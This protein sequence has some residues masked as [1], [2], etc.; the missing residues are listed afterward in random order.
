MVVL[1]SIVYNLTDLQARISL[2]AALRCLTKRH[3]LAGAIIIAVVVIGLTH[4]PV[5][6]LPYPAA[7]G[8]AVGLAVGLGLGF[9]FGLR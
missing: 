2:V 6:A 8:L 3:F 7:L 4:E 9:A 5:T 1:P